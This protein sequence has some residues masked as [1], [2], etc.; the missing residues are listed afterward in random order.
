MRAFQERHFGPCVI[1]YMVVLKNNIGEKM[2]VWWS[3]WCNKNSC[4]KCTIWQ[5]AKMNYKEFE[6]N[7]FLKSMD[8]D[9][10]LGN[11]WYLPQRAL[12]SVQNMAASVLRP[13]ERIKK[14]SQNTLRG[15]RESNKR[16]NLSSGADKHSERRCIVKIQ[17]HKSQIYNMDK[18]DND[19]SK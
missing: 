1:N 17:W 13:P 16:S 11:V 15:K 5:P 7:N 9:A 18:R 10:C 19:T 12:Q 4:K 3:E 2:P 14:T 8:D 6:I